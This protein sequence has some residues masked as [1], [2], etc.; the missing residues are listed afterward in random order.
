MLSSRLFCNS[1]LLFTLPFLSKQTRH[2]RNI[3]SFHFFSFIT[4]RA[5]CLSREQCVCGATHVTVAALFCSSSLLCISNSDWATENEAGRSVSVNGNEGPAG[6]ISPIQFSCNYNY[7]LITN[8]KTPV[9]CTWG[10]LSVC[11]AC[12]TTRLNLTSKLHPSWIN[13]CHLHNR[14]TKRINMLRTDISE[15]C[16]CNTKHGKFI[17]RNTGTII[18]LMTICTIF[19]FWQFK[20]I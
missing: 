2:G 14:I 11:A 1:H 13:V 15:M 6:E 17:F 12:P 20:L 8:N 9:H 16:F 19:F 10:L 18:I 7:S 5:R 3:I 4:G